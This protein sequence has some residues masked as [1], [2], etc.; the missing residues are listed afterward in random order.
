VGLFGRGRLG[1]AIAAAA[2][3][4]LAWS[5]GRGDRPPDEPRVAVAIDAS[6]GVAVRDHL[7]WAVDH[8]VD[9]VIGA[10][11]IDMEIESLKARVS[12]RIGV[13]VA[14]NFSLGIALYARLALVLARFA[15]A[16]PNTDPY[17]VEHHHARK[18]D[19]PSGTA[20]MLAGVVRKGF[21]AKTSWTSPGTGELRP[22]QLNVSAVRAGHTFSS[23]VVGIDAPAETIEIHHASRS[24][25]AYAH[26]A[27][28]V[29]DWV[30]GRRGLFSFNDF[31]EE[32]LAP[33][34]ADVSIGG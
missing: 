32:R 18:R 12:N 3:E 8:G 21:P 16:A 23:H 17:I 33:F 13:V 30:R 10:T 1:S 22:D 9:L 24:A 26:G 4:R 5:L 6:V 2:G 28:A 19:A 11:G 31:A 15:A 14:P 25:A 27:L 34:F 7:D 29:A 20:R